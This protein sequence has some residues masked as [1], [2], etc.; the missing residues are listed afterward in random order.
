MIQLKVNQ[1]DYELN[2]DPDTPLLWVLK[3]HLNLNGTKYSCGVGVCGACSVLV[4]GSVVRSCV[5]SAQSVA[6][7]SIVTIE[8]LDEADPLVKAVLEAWELDNVAQCGYC[9][10]GQIINAVGV[11]ARA[12]ELS[13]DEVVE[14]MTGNLC[15][16]GSY[17]R[18]REALIK[19]VRERSH[20]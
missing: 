15:R 7:K 3:D 6:G 4:D 16:C 2:I 1:R 12:S 18:I 5:L 19:L 20:A 9:Q 13:A 14:Q 8:G 17:P 10:P 11:L